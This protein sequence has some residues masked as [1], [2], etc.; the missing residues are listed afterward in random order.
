MECCGLIICPFYLKHHKHLSTLRY[1][2]QTHRLL[3]RSTFA[4]TRAVMHAARR[5][6]WR[7][8][9]DY[10]FGSDITFKRIFR[11]FASKPPQPRHMLVRDIPTATGLDHRISA[12]GRQKKKKTAKRANERNYNKRVIHDWFRLNKAAAAADFVCD[13]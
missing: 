13:A 10:R 4:T 6:R 5:K 2:T 1:Q 8:N 12:G 7:Y 11:S 9:L 3:V